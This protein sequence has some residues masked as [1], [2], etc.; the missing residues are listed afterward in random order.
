VDT[1]PAALDF[2]LLFESVPDL[3]LVLQPDE[4]FYILGASDAYLRATHITREG[5]VGRGLFE[6]FPD[7]PDDPAATGTSNLRAS[8]ER[9]LATRAADAM[10]VQKYD[11]RR[12]ESEGGGFEKRFWS[13]VNTPVLSSDG[14]VIYIIHRVQDVTEFVQVSRMGQLERERSQILQQRSEAMEHEILARSQELDSANRKLRSVNAHLAELDVAKTTFFNNISHEFRTPLTLMLGPVEDALRDAGAPLS[15]RQRARLELVHHN[16]LRLLK[17]VTALLDFSRIEAGRMR[18]TYAPTDLSRVTAELAAAFESAITRANLALVVEC[19]PLSEPAY[20]DRD[21]WEKIVL[22]LISNAFKFTFQGRIAVRVSEREAHFELSVEDTGAGIA[23]EELPH[24][25]ERFHRVQG[26]RSRS[27]E[28]TGIGLSL[29]QE[30]ATLHGGTVS[31]I[32]VVDRGTTFR[33]SIPKGMQHLPAE[34]I[35]TPDAA[36][37]AA[38]SADAFSSEAL[39]WLPDDVTASAASGLREESDDAD[40]KASRGRILLVD[41][42]AELRAYMT[43]LLEPHFAVQVAVDGEAA[44]ERSCEWLPDL[45]VSDVMMPR[46]DG[47]GLLRALRSNPRTQTIPVILLSARA[48]EES[49]VEGFEAGADDY[50]VKPFAAR[51]LLARVRTHLQLARLR[52]EWAS[53]LERANREL[54]AFSYSVSHDLR[55]PLRAIEGFSKG[56]LEDYGQTHDP[57]LREDLER[58]VSSSTRM[59]ALIE[60]LLGLARITQVALQKKPVELT[61]L[62][63]GVVAELRRGSPACDGSVEVADGLTARG[64]ER[65]LTIALENLIGNAVKFTSRR[66]RPHIV[67]GQEQHGAETVFYVRDNGAGF[68]M[69]RANRLFTPFERLHHP[70]EFDGTGVGLATVHRIITRHG[71]RIWAEAAVDQGA[72]FFFTLGDGR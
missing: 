19:A 62:A 37:P 15:P 47:F 57:R 13:P 38:A 61:A 24:I 23:Q 5:S 21:M 56:L 36:V 4:D 39:R 17:L 43:Q 60:D 6:V 51:E 29:V 1:H 63:R 42:N 14:K 58:I 45:V 35:A 50:L 11:V 3:L 18:A 64:D 20:V 71:G 31:V 41:D 34:S 65:L 27:Y 26:A 44:L 32:S 8:L 25:F 7:N 72:T 10:A 9:V 55:A 40:G 28:G 69:K 22:N 16:A 67:I 49:T 2:K 66:T 33:V 68:D 53:E 70:S 48:G 54:E 52:R 59:F 12:P 46:L 30:L